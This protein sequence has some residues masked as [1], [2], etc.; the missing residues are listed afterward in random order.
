MSR[1]R[2]GWLVATGI[3]IA[4]LSLPASAQPVLYRWT[5]K[6]GKVH[7]GDKPAPGA[8]EVTRIEIDAKPSGAAPAPAP[9]PP[10]PAAPASPAP[11]VARDAPPAGD[12]ASQRRATRE[13]LQAALDRARARLEAAKKA[14]DDSSAMEEG[15]RQTIV[16]SAGRAPLAGTT[17]MNCRQVVGKDRKTTTVCPAVVPNEQYYERRAGLEEAV[18][19]AEEE[20]AAAENAYRRGAD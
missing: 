16:R 3:F 20:L 9:L 13:R 19:A 1:P 17:R 6:A 4:V 11:E 14:L 15:E 10:V 2:T 5:D 7:Y 8:L 12:L 18:R